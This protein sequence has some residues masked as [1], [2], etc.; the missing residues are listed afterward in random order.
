MRYLIFMARNP[1]D[2]IV[3]SYQQQQLR[4]TGSAEV[5]FNSDNWVGYATKQAEE[6]AASWPSLSAIFRELGSRYL[7]VR[8]EHLLDPKRYYEILV[9]IITFR[10]RGMTPREELLA[11][12]NRVRCLDT[13]TSKRDYDT[14]DTQ[15]FIGEPYLDIRFVRR[16]SKLLEPYLQYFGYPTVPGARFQPGFG[17]ISRHHVPNMVAFLFADQSITAVPDVIASALSSQVLAVGKGNNSDESVKTVKDDQS[18]LPLADLDSMEFTHC[19]KLNLSIGYSKHASLKS[20]NP[21][22]LLSLPGSGDV[23]IRKIIE[24]TTG[25]YTGSLGHV[26]QDHKNSKDF[27]A[28]G[29]CGSHLAAIYCQ[30][31]NFIS[32]ESSVVEASVPSL[33]QTSVLQFA[34]KHNIHRNK[35]RKLKGNKFEKIILM[36]RNPFDAIIAAY[37]QVKSESF[38]LS[39]LHRPRNN[40]DHA[41]IVDVHSE[42]WANFVHHSAQMYHDLWMLTN[43]SFT[44]VSTTSSRNVFVVKFEDLLTS[45]TAA[46]TGSG[47]EL[48]NNLASFIGNLETTEDEVIRS[49]RMQ[50]IP[51]LNEFAFR[52]NIQNL[53]FTDFP[54]SS[55]LLA[56]TAALMD[57]YLQGLQYE[58]PSPDKYIIVKGSVGSSASGISSTNKYALSYSQPVADYTPPL[59]LDGSVSNFNATPRCAQHFGYRIFKLEPDP[60]PLLVSFAGSGNTWVRLLIEFATGI[61]SGSTDTSDKVLKDEFIGERHCNRRTSVI[62][63]HPPQLKYDN[64]TG[65]STLPNTLQLLKCSNGG[66]YYFKRYVFLVRDPFAAIFAEVNRELTSSHGG[67]AVSVDTF[68]AKNWYQLIMEEARDYSTSWEKLV[69]GLQQRRQKLLAD[70]GAVDEDANNFLILARYEWLVHSE[71]RYEELFRIAQWIYPLDIPTLERLQCAFIQSDLSSVHRIKNKDS[72]TAALLYRNQSLVDEIWE[73]VKD[74]AAFAGYEKYSSA[75]TR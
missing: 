67:T 49:L 63:V 21:P 33:A 6:Y 8:Y 3:R 15:G 26:E 56:D 18:M 5:N 9:G 57:G 54:F 74:F 20:S 69:S 64:G 16:L 60:P 25:L 13:F 2:A 30:H 70:A 17:E 4:S 68:M 23:W 46:A 10:V 29:H 47:S 11:S 65:R 31:P 61:F 35:C 42:E 34:L 28:D 55:K 58:M 36:V 27:I 1:Y 62:K 51:L 24:M 32:K 38:L 41:H 39:K 37:A 52:E 66:M 53:K 22:L 40:D 12:I 75:D 43:A 14:V 59:I 45:M 19:A 73:L 72:M 50:C 44:D 7:I 71:K 48:V